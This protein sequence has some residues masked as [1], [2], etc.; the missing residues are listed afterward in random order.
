MLFVDRSSIASWESGRRTPDAALIGGLAEALKVSPDKLLNQLDED[1]SFK[2]CAILV[3]DEKIILRGGLPVLERVMPDS[4]VR[5]FTNPLEAVAFSRQTKVDLAFIDIEM[6]QYS[7]LDVCK[8]LVSINPK[9]NVI[10]LTSHVDYALDAWATGACGFMLKPLT[11][12]GIRNQFP[13]LRYPIKGL[14]RL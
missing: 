1:T 3:D 6:G 13:L 9:I 12:E 7:G 4:V 14:A 8:E 10:Y 5:G 2:T 11:V